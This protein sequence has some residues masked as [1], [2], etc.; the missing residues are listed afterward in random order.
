M[1]R[2]AERNVYLAS[3]VLTITSLLISVIPAHAA[4]SK[5]AS[6]IVKVNDLSHVDRLS[7]KFNWR[8]LKTVRTG[9]SAIFVIEDVSEGQLK[10]LL[11][12]E[13]G[14]VFAAE[15]KA[16][17]LDGGETVLPLD[18]GETV[19]PL[20]GGET[21][22]PLGGSEDQTI[23]Q[24]LDGGETV[25]PLDELNT[26]RNAYTAIAKLVTPS[27]RLIL[28]AAFRK[29]GLY[30]SV[31]KATGRGVIIADLDTG[32]DTC[33]E[34]LHGIV[35]YTFVDGADANAPENCPTSST[36]V[37]PGYG[38][39]TRVA[40]LLRLVAPEA[41]IWAVRVFDNTGSAQISTIY[42]AV[43]FAADHGV[44]VINMSFGTTTPSEALQD[45][46]D[47]ARSRGVTLV[48]AGGNSNAEPLMYPAQYPGVKGVAGVTN[49]DIKTSFSNYG[50]AA[51]V[52]AP[53]YGLWVAHPN[54]QMAYVAGTSY[55]SPL[56]AAEAA[57][58]I[59]SFQRV[60]R[61]QPGWSYVNFMMYY[62]NQR[63]DALNPQYLGKLG[64]GR[65][66][67]PLSLGGLTSTSAL[68]N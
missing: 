59:D 44:D 7:R 51:F 35:T 16:L 11:K 45:A 19:L 64:H 66:Y 33:H 65:I 12:N 23:S 52:S 22:L 24:L 58:V 30:P 63:I 20:D 41:T 60:F 47:Y 4:A 38:H 32:A 46:L 49:A 29:I 56:A 39:G 42:E 21:V 50:T 53:A 28:Q 5:K 37:V 48:A 6:V 9:T 13:D 40:S 10:Q 34:V 14:F 36:P 25:L 17:P 61:G 57:L 55:A 27:A 31:S 18:G 43:T 3:A 54:H 8:V 68:V 62:G 67:I 1:R 15:N 2:I 26:I